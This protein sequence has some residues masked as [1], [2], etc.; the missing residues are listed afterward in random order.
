M[1]QM[2]ADE[3]FFADIKSFTSIIDKL[4][5]PNDEIKFTKDEKTKLTFRLKENVDHMRKQVKKGFFIKRW[6][7]KSI[8]NQYNSIL[9]NHF[10]D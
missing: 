8:L 5:D 2:T 10:K 4:N 3:K 7:Y 6:F 9:E 1:K